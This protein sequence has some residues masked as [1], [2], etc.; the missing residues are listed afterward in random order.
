MTSY[1]YY[2]GCSMDSSARVLPRIAD[3]HRRARSASSSGDRRLELL[4]RDRVPGRQPDAGLRADRPQPGPRRAARPTGPEPSSRRAAPATSTWPR[5]TTTWPRARPSAG[6]STRRWRPAALHYT[7]GSLEIRHLLDVIVNDVGLDAVRRKVVRPLKGLRVAPYLGCMVPRPDYDQRLDRSR[8]SR[9]SSDQLL[10][11]LGAE[12]IDFPLKTDC[13]GG[14][15]TQIS[16]PTA[17][18]LIRRLVAYGRRRLGADMMVTRLPDVPDEPRRLPGR[19]EPPLQDELQDADPVLHPADGPGLRASKPEALG[20]GR[21]LVDARPGARPGSAWRCRRREEAS[22]PAAP[23]QA[24][25]D[26]GPPDAAHA[27]S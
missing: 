21:E 10:A 9:R 16:P 26:A 11:A 5:P 13:C 12:V 15:M 8:A 1:L 6:K 3:G 24:Q 25:E 4:R 19:D 2:P 23:A 14:H 22:G 17:F 18:E 7:P 27:R 20:F